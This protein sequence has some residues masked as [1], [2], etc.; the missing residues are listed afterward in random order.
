MAYP[1]KWSPISYNSSTGQRKHIGQRPMLYR[2]TTQPTINHP[3][4]DG[5]HIIRRIVVNGA[6]SLSLQVYEG[7]GRGRRKDEISGL[8]RC[9]VFPSA[10]Q[11]SSRK[12][13]ANATYLDQKRS[14][15]EELEKERNSRGN[16]KP[17][18]NRKM[19]ARTQVVTVVVVECCCLKVRRTIIK[20]CSVQYCVQQ[21]CTVQCTHIR[22]GL[23]VVHRVGGSPG[24]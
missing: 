12:N 19:A 5:I 1:H 11:H 7:G 20:I 2:C 16:R 17:K 4:E 10:L 24:L 8:G 9:F 14:V 3:V 6:P 15:P 21:L 22:I 23:T 18:F 13:G